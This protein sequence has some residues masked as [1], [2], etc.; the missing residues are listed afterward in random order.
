MNRSQSATEFMILIAAVL[1]IFLPLFYIF[2]HYGLQSG[3]EMTSAKVIEIGNKLTL[4]AREI[5]FL[6]L[7]SKE[8]LT[9]NVPE[10]ITNMHTL[11]I[12]D[13]SSN[14]EQY[15]LIINYTRNAD[16]IEVTIPAEI[17]I[18]SD[19]CSNLA[20]ANCPLGV[21]AGYDCLKCN[22]NRLAYTQG[23][24]D[25]KLEAFDSTVIGKLAVNISGS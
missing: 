7:W 15:Y 2:T 11:Y 9:I 5:Y 14:S 21:G 3:T 6:G 17:P 24:R 13:A 20:N 19:Q 10:G 12:I 23:T 16:T 18:V 22:L 1:L 4:E 8:I 25:I